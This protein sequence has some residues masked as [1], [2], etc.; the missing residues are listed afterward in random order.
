MLCNINDDW[1]D[2]AIGDLESK[3]GDFGVWEDKDRDNK[4]EA[5]M[6]CSGLPILAWKCLFVFLSML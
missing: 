1:Q 5:G 4:G 3:K 6:A 2:L